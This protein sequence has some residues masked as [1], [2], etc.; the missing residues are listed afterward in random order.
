MINIMK[1][2]IL[3]VIIFLALSWYLFFFRLD[4]MGLTDPDET[5]YAQTAKEMLSK[6]EWLVPHIFGKPQFE[7]PVFFYWLVEISFKAFGVNETAARLPSAVF[8][9]IGIAATYFLGSLLFNKRTGLLGAIMLATSV[10]YIILSRA[11]VTDMTLFSLML[12][13]ALFFFYG[14]LK[15]RLYAYLL[16]A[17]FFALAVLTKGPIAVML[18]GLALILYFVF[19]R[20]WKSFTKIPFLRMTA[21]FIAVA[22]PWYL[23]M[24]K[25]HGNVFIDAFFGF[26][27]IIRFT[28]SEHKIGSQVWYNIPILLGGFFPWSVFL[29]FGLWSAIKKVTSGQSPVTGDQR[30]GHVFALTWFFSIFLFFTVS[31]TKLPTYIFP[32]FVAATLIAAASWDE[33]LKVRPSQMTEKWV[34]GA[35]YALVV[36][37]ILGIA[38]ASIYLSGHYPTLLTSLVI[39]FSILLF[40]ILMSLVAILNGKKLWTFMLIA[41]AILIFLYPASK[42]ALPELEKFETSKA[43]AVKL[44]ALMSPGERLGSEDR[45]MEGLTFYTGHIPEN[46]GNSDNMANFLNSNDR[47]WCLLK[48]RNNI[49][50]S[51]L[52]AY[53][54]YRFGKMVILTN[55]LPESEKYPIERGG[56]K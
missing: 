23:A 33:F 8:G 56:V 45:Y 26:Q 55:K 53:V 17:A 49:E 30:K 29:P 16:S 10:E 43:V 3:P 22:A 41:Y 51:A 38:G 34:R 36:I 28:Q 1:R 40:G 44:N 25:V 5:F 12:L 20:D 39:P 35:C 4:A 46:L 32:C 2:P 14:H 54:V 24:Y 42:L 27:N 18:P 9:M 19:I 21:V 50:F 48:D 7:K 6:N 37:V 13:G 31:S 15:D 11:C 52:G 47:V